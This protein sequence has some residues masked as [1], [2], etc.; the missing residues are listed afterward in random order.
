MQITNT[1]DSPQVAVT[2]FAELFR[3]LI[4][5]E[6]EALLRVVWSLELL[7]ERTRKYL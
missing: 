6:E 3:Y 2:L 4:Y 5:E 7:E 1:T